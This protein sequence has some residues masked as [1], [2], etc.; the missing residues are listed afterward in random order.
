MTFGG[1]PDDATTG[2]THTQK[3]DAK[4]DMWWTVTLG[5]VEYGGENMKGS[6]INYAILDTGSSYLTIG[7]ED[8]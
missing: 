1:E 4:N 7:Q 2:E 8:F 3:L 5:S 6:G